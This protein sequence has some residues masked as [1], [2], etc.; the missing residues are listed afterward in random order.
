MQSDN[1]PIVKL[2]RRERKSLRAR[3][4]THNDIANSIANEGAK[5]LDRPGSRRRI[6][7]LGIPPRRV[8]V[9]ILEATQFLFES[10]DALLG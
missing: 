3:S 2:C 9:F 8:A 10:R 1:S 5:K 4:G 6:H 7:D